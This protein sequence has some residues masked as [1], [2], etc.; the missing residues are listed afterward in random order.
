MGVQIP[1]EQVPMVVKAVEH[2]ADYLKATNRDD[3]AFREL[4]ESLKRKPSVKQQS[5][6]VKRK[7]A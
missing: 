1:D 3:R 7:R 6:P 2:Y 4:T 5:E